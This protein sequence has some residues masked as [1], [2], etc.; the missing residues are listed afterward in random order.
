MK[1]CTAF[2]ECNARIV[3]ANPSG[4]NEKDYR[5][6]ESASYKERDVKRVEENIGPPLKFEQAYKVLR[7]HPKFHMVLEVMKREPK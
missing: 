7:D 2:A 3:R 1:S 5:R 4:V 6:L